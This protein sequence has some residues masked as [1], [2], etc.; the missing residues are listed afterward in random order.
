M[1]FISRLKDLKDLPNA[2]I[3][4]CLTFHGQTLGPVRIEN[5]RSQLK[6]F[7]IVF[8]AERM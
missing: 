1:L 5:M 7:P 6:F 8:E 4:L 3:A 2:K